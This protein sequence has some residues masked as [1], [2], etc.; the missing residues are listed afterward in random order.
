LDEHIKRL[1]KKLSLAL[2]K[3]FSDSTEISD[4]VQEIKEKGYNVFL[5]LEAKIGLSQKDINE[6]SLEK[7]LMDEKA[8]EK[9]DVL[10]KN[11]SPEDRDFLR[12]IKIKIDEEL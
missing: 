5:L 11:I 2:R 7:D 4:I 6:Y 8:E 10:G 1:I 12:S 9:K 3:A